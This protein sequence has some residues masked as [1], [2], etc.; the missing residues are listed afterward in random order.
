MTEKKPNILVVFGDQ[1]RGQAFGY[2]DDPNVQT[3]NI[4]K[5][6]GE[7]LNFEN[8]ISGCPVCC[9]ARASLLTG[10]SPLTH[11]VIVNDVS[12]HQDSLSMGK[13]FSDNGYETAY[14]GKWH[15]D[16][17]GRSNFIPRERRGGFDYW[18]VLECT[19]NY[20]E[21]YYYSSDNKEKIKWDGYDAI[22]QTHD[23]IEYINDRGPEDDPFLMVLSWGPPH[24]PYNT[25]PLEYRSLYEPK[26]LELRSNV[27][28]NF[29]GWARESLSGYYAHCTALD[30]C[31]GKLLQ[32]I[33]R[34]GLTD[35]TIILFFSDHGDMVGSHGMNN[36]QKPWQES[37]SIP[38]LLKYPGRFGCEGKVL[39]APIDI[40]DIL[41]TLMGL[42]GI[43][44]SDTIEGRDFTDY[45][46][47]GPDPSNGIAFLQCP[48]PFGQWWPGAG[49][50]S[51]RGI[52]DE[53]YTYVRALE[54]PWLF[55]DNERDPYQLENLLGNVS[56]NN[57]W[58]ELDAELKRQLLLR[59]DDFLPGPAYLDHFGYEV[60]ARGTVRYSL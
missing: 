21:S 27:P 48:H 15:V 58:L 7:S 10:Q 33:D 39:K 32:E 43:E 25:A 54:G 12:L 13:I 28:E 56:H 26:D 22:A 38:F 24:D 41:P 44:V 31:M 60:E 37:I 55:Y 59:N 14:I 17:R 6:A 2:A 11:G 29:V 30:D 49:G 5:M 52:R 53:R 40:P 16:G 23:A 9:P 57:A 36:K 3:P 47:G 51:Y 4:D 42:C 35:D 19:H 34:N 50:R 1:W 46:C 18:K 20:N 45:I 8:A